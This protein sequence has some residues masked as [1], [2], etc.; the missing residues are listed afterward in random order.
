MQIAKVLQSLLWVHHNLLLMRGL[1]LQSSKL[2]LKSSCQLWTFL[3]LP[4]LRL[5]CL[6]PLRFPSLLFPSWSK[7]TL[8]QHVVLVLQQWRNHWFL[9]KRSPMMQRAQE[10]WRSVI[11]RV[12]EE[13]ITQ[14]WR[15]NQSRAAG[16][17]AVRAYNLLHPHPYA[18]AKGLGGV[19][20]ARGRLS[21]QLGAHKSSSEGGSFWEDCIL[22]Y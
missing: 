21:R 12:D 10:W 7:R 4:L 15:N 16:R 17:R 2:L 14:L 3:Y 8:P 20:A 11:G 6:S 22:P 19:W 5:L 1:P 9:L 18:Y 13:A